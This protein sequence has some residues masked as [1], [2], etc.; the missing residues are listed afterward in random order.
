MGAH[1]EDQGHDVAIEAELAAIRLTRL[2][3][4]TITAATIRKWASRGHV[5]RTGHRGRAAL[6]SMVELETY[7]G[8]LNKTP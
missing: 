3:G 4:R 7:A 5:K 1:G 6:Y 8:S 2:T